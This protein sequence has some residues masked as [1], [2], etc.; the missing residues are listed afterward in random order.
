MLMETYNYPIMADLAV[1]LSGMYLMA[2]VTCNLKVHL[3]AIT[4]SIS[5]SDFT[6]NFYHWNDGTF[7]KSLITLIKP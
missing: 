7:V 6:C 1:F 4:K 3:F 5:H 2:R